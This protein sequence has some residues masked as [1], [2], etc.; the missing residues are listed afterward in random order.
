MKRVAIAALAL[1]CLAAITGCMPN[2]SFDDPEPTATAQQSA[3]VSWRKEFATQYKAIGV[4]AGLVSEA[5]GNYDFAEADRE[6]EAAVFAAE[7]GADIADDAG[8]VALGDDMDSV[9]RW[10][11]K[12]KEEMLNRDWSSAT[13][14]LDS[15]VVYYKSAMTK[16]FNSQDA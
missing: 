1:S 6:V 2:I 10:L 3:D 16:F 9:A 8:Q 5:L 14:Y 7:W 15:A 13:D 4:H 11:S 12:A